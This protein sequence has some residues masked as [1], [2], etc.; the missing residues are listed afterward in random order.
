ME[1]ADAIKERKESSD[2]ME[3]CGGASQTSKICGR[4]WCP[5]PASRLMKPLLEVGGLRTSH[6]TRP[7]SSQRRTLLQTYALGKSDV[8]SAERMTTEGALSPLFSF[9]IYSVHLFNLCK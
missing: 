5:R 3:I 6:D 2:V 4:L 1:Q 8:I 7:C 9:S